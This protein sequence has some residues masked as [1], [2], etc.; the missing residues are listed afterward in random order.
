MKLKELTEGS[1]SI[2]RWHSSIDWEQEIKSVK[3][4]SR[5]IEP[6]DIFVAVKGEYH[7]GHQ[8]AKQ[9]LQ[10]GAVA[11]IVEDKGYCAD[12]EPWILAKSSRDVYGVMAQNM[13]GKPSLM[14]NVIGVTGT[15]GKTTTAHMIAAILEE[16]GKRTSVLGTIYNRI[17]N[18]R[19]D[20][21]LTTPD[22]GELA[23][24]FRQM[25]EAQTEYAVMEVSSHAL[26]QSRVA[27]IEYD[28]AIF[29][30]LSQ[31]HLDYHQDLESYF[32]AKARL[33]S[34]L[35]PQGEKKRKKVAVINLDDA[36]GERLMDYCSTPVITYGF[37]ALCQL[38]AEEAS[39]TAS[40]IRYRL[41]NGAETH[42]IKMHLHG[43]FN[44]YNSLAAIGAAL[45][46]GVDME[47]IKKALAEMPPVPGRF[48]QVEAPGAPLPF[49]VF[50]DYSHTPD[51]IEK[52]LSSAREICTGRI[53][54]VF[55]A[56]GHRDATKR[57]K[58]GEAAAR[59]S[60]IAIVTSDNPRD[61]EPFAIMQD[62]LEGMDSPSAIAEILT[63]PDR[64]K[65]IALAI[66]KAKQGDMVLICGKG[67]EDY[68][69]IGNDRL[70]FDDYTEAQ[71]HMRGR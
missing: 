62:I 46:E 36:A 6:G 28:L 23:D 59:L 9:A 20:A 29:T 13:A 5:A 24:L 2:C 16:A 60:D 42:E 8:Y 67:H 52:C 35:K 40:G 26:D 14:M 43:R 10:K 63:E 66:S 64:G 19:F 68:Q 27:G 65:A 12:G 51:S 37:G 7:D 32:G 4:D 39:L 25:A 69:I 58:M 49:Q 54:S 57:P 71:K 11:L 30:N 3:A 18:Q 48:Q 41:I 47:T 17:G 55:G 38:R 15:N 53:I 1:V 21:Q 31:D 50:V 70:P 44:V 56:G 22:C 34:G 61:E 45:V 33:F